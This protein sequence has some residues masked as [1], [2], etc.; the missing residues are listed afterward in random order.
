MVV[1]LLSWV[2]AFHWLGYRVEDAA[3]RAFEWHRLDVLNPARRPMTLFLE[4]VPYVVLGAAAVVLGLRRG[5]GW[6]AAE[7]S[8][9]RGL[10]LILAFALVHANRPPRWAIIAGAT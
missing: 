8:R 1:A 2:A 5:T 9:N 7:R 4:R 10:A 6:L 3:L